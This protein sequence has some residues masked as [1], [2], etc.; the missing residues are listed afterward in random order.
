[1]TVAMKEMMRRAEAESA[2]AKAQL[3]ALYERVQTKDLSA[4]EKA[5]IEVA[6]REIKA[7]LEAHTKSLP[8][9]H[10]KGHPAP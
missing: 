5:R 1:M 8:T 4:D 2:R 3:V 6:I 9:N 10:D 7:K